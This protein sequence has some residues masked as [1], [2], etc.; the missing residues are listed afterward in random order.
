MQRKYITA[1][2][3]VLV[4]CSLFLAACSGAQTTTA[5]STVDANA[6]YTQA[7]QTVDASIQ[8]TEAAR[9]SETSTATI[10]PTNTLDPTVAEAL[11]STANA[12]LNPPVGTQTP[13]AGTT[14]TTPDG[15]QA[16]ATLQITPLIQPTATTAGGGAAVPAPSSD[17]KAQWISSSPDDGIVVQKEASWD[18]TITFKNTGTSTWSTT[19]ALKYW[20]GDRMDSPVDFYLQREVKPGDSYSFIFPMKA[21]NTAGEKNV[22]WALQNDEG[23]NF[24]WVSLQV[25]VAE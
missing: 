3:S 20:G 4:V 18:Q 19:Y 22:M 16:T 7:A 9:P 13:A 5:T 24:S 12:V 25:I 14:E 23:Y 2:V 6:I 15:T 17:D 8:M 11:T 21:P 1:G 10:E